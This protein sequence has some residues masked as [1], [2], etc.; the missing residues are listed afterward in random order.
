MRKNDNGAYDV[1]LANGKEA[2]ILAGAVGM[3]VHMLT[4]VITGTT[5]KTNEFEFTDGFLEMAS[6][7][8][9]P[10]S[11]AVIVNVE[12]DN[13]FSADNFMNKS[14]GRSFQTSIAERYDAFDQERW[15]AFNMELNGLEL[16]WLQAPQEEK[17]AIRTK[18]VELKARRT[19]WKQIQKQKKINS[20]AIKAAEAAAGKKGRETD[21]LSKAGSQWLLL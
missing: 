10:G 3:V 16:S 17:A 6:Q 15:D 19:R 20:A 5:I 1:R 9:V 8:I 4:G 12:E 2:G 7:K 11:V 14:G 18:I 13:G 21:K